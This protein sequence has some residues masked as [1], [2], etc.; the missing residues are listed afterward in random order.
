MLF[1]NLPSPFCELNKR[2]R[3]ISKINDTAYTKRRFGSICMAWCCNRAFRG[4][5]C[6]NVFHRSLRSRYISSLRKRIARL[7]KTYLHRRNGRPERG[8]NERNR[9]ERRICFDGIPDCSQDAHHPT[10]GDTTES[11]IIRT[12]STAIGLLLVEW[13]PLTHGRA[14]GIEAREIARRVSLV[15]FHVS[16]TNVS[17]EPA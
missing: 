9:Y 1:S 13:K 10:D 2:K 17:R 11:E 5:S 3:L 15:P 6:C 12:C 7:F 4:H 14:P 8:T 16:K